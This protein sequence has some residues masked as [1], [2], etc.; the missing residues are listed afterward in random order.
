M[1]ILKQAS[2]HNL[3]GCKCDQTIQAW[4]N[5]RTPLQMWSHSQIATP[6]GCSN[7]QIRVQASFESEGAK[8]LQECNAMQSKARNVNQPRTGIIRCDANALR[9]KIYFFLLHTPGGPGQPPTTQRDGV[10]LEGDRR[11]CCDSRG[12]ALR[13]R[14]PSPLRGSRS[15][16]GVSRPG[17]VGGG[18]A[19]APG[20]AVCHTPSQ[21]TVEI[22][23][24][25][26]GRKL[27][28]RYPAPFRWR[29][30]GCGPV[31]LRSALD[32]NE[33]NYDRRRFDPGCGN[34]A[35][36]NSRWASR[37][38]LSKYAHHPFTFI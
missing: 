14:R 38:L 5:Y 17:C 11:S 13:S 9:R 16:V 10:R 25:H 33:I 21:G 35:R 22:R 1:K 2:S 24:C 36:G 30:R 6:H 4:S 26:R 15:G 8:K 32:K 37:L 28:G 34:S 7:F 20:W 12:G 31:H 27:L 29:N 19:A 23:V 18:A 3:R